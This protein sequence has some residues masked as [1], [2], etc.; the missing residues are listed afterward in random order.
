MREVNED[1][2][3]G[4]WFLP[5]SRSQL[6]GLL[7]VTD[8][9]INLNITSASDRKLSPEE[10]YDPSN[11]IKYPVI[12]GIGQYQEKITLLECEGHIGSFEAK[13]M[14]YGDRHY[15]AIDKQKFQISAVHIPLLDQWFLG[16]SFRINNRNESFTLE[17]N[18]PKPFVIPLDDKVSIELHYECSTPQA[19]ERN[20]IQIHHFTL[21]KFVTHDPKGLILKEIINYAN[22]LQQLASFLTGNGANISTIRVYENKAEFQRNPFL[23]TQIYGGRSFNKNEF[24]QPFSETTYLFKKNELGDNFEQFIVNWFK[25]SEELQHILKL[26]FLDYYNRGTF[27]EN[28][29]LNL[30]RTLEV[31]HRYLYPG[32]LMP[33]EQFKLKIE[34]IIKNIPQEFKKE[35]KDHLQF[36]NEYTLDQRLEQLFA[37]IPDRRIRPKYIYDNE[38]KKNIKNSRNYYTH[39]SKHLKGKAKAGQELEEL[40]ESMRALINYLLLK[41]LDVPEKTLDRIFEFYIE[42]IFYS[43]TF[44]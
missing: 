11:L 6:Q 18:K 20:R 41:H 13:L 30:I 35:V 34:K 9:Y 40:T 33:P 7:S 42:R 16:K 39:Y 2:Y 12:H 8:S 17:Y 19:K 22:R 24:Y 5:N 25:I 43:Q 3:H 28:N 37:E 31:F 15:T 21:V 4:V 44:N 38:F 29:F 26:I 1:E 14:F 27:D 32:T 23:G 10:S 36:K